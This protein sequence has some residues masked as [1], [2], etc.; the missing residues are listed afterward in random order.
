MN[1]MSDMHYSDM[2][3]RK[4]KLFLIVG[5]R[6]IDEGIKMHKPEEK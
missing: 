6:S 4:C 3:V 2:C 5:P 1:K